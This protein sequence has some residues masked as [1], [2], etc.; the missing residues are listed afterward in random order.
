MHLF[1]DKS[2]IHYYNDCT[3]SHVIVQMN[4]LVDSLSRTFIKYDKEKNES[5]KQRSSIPFHVS[6]ADRAIP[7]GHNVYLPTHD[8]VYSHLK[9]AHFPYIAR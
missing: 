7:C 6:E 8:F 1:F 4:A 2:K 5:V 9:N 3:P